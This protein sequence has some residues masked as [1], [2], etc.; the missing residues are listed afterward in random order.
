MSLLCSLGRHQPGP[1]PRWNDGFYFT[2]CQR[3]G[4]DLVRTAFERW[5]L[6]D[7]YRV[8]WSPTPPEERPDVALLRTPPDASLPGAEPKRDEEA[9]ITAAPPGPEAA[10]LAPPPASAAEDALGFPPAPADEPREQAPPL[11]QSEPEAPEPPPEPVVEEPAMAAEPPPEPPEMGRSRLPIEEVLDQLRAEGEPP[12]APAQSGPAAPQRG[13]RRY[14]D[15]MDEESSETSRPSS[16]R[17]LPTHPRADDGSGG[18]STDGLTET[19]VAVLATA[20]HILVGAGSA[21]KRAFDA[22]ARAFRAGAERPQPVLGLALALLVTAIIAATLAMTTGL[23][24]A[25]QSPRRPADAGGDAAP[26]TGLPAGQGAAGSEPAQVSGA[27]RSRGRAYVAASLLSCRAGPTREARRVR[28]V[29]RGEPVDI[30]A[31]DGEW[32]SIAY[33]GRQC[34]AQ[35]KFIS[36]LPPY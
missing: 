26:A 6:P 34:W 29:G 2:T 9:A 10:F 7:G 21:F 5:H 24:L 14:W 28:N 32:L 30:L 17:E 12:S 33:Q 31:D 11:Q 18:R 8:V 15:F 16:G 1:L 25:D 3:C 20:R 4:R 27:S 23:R 35:A 19:A 13:P 22:G 36:P